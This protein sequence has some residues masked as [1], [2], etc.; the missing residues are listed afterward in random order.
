MRTRNMRNL[1]GKLS[2]GFA[3]VKKKKLYWESLS[4]LTWISDIVSLL[5]GEGAGALTS[6]GRAHLKVVNV[7]LL[8]RRGA[9][10]E[11]CFSL[12]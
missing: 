5:R 6:F 4:P 9:W 12:L 2:I 11:G 8:A 3:L 1:R 7:D 10:G